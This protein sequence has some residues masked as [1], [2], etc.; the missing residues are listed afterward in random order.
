M[1]QKF[2]K[3]VTFSRFQGRWLVYSV[4]TDKAQAEEEAAMYRGAWVEEATKED[5]DEYAWRS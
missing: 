2:W 1:K 3:I 5:Y 4:H